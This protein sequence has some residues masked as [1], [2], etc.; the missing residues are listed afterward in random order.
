MLAT[1]FATSCQKETPRPSG[2][3]NGTND[4]RFA[5]INQ[6]T[7]DY[8]ARVHA[9]NTANKPIGAV[10]KKVLKVVGADLAGAV[11]GG[12]KGAAAGAAAGNPVGG[13]VAGAIAGGAAASI[14]EA[15]TADTP[16]APVQ[17]PKSFTPGNTTSNPGNSFDYVG[18]WHYK[19]INDAVVSTGNYL[20]NNVYDN[21][22]FYPFTV[23]LLMSNGIVSR[24]ASS[25]YSQTDGN[26][27]L[28]DVAQLSSITL[29]DYIDQKESNNVIS[30]DVATVLRQYAQCLASLTERSDVDDFVSYSVQIENLVA[31]AGLSSGD[32][33]L[34]LQ[35]MATGRYGLQYWTR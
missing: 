5:K 30:A 7:A 21:T 29:V 13:A 2:A 4:T 3:Q 27:T 35:V 34:V 18:Y 14:K 17:Q 31:G 26:N 11:D 16:P 15:T 32:Q 6:L 28:A 10:L 12:A 20:T 33:Q 19:S 24:N 9:T 8:L 22:L 23:N 25:Y 1:L